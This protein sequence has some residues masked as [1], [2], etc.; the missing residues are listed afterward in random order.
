MT[1]PS[2]CF[3]RCHGLRLRPVPELQTCLVYRP[4]PPRLFR[5]N[6]SAWLVLELCDGLEWAALVEAYR[7]MA[8]NHSSATEVTAQV[9]E[10]LRMLMA[11]GLV[12]PASAA[13]TQGGEA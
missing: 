2:G 10:G 12:S 9:A 8:G 3:S 13:A 7:K 5:L 11:V 1:F 4:R 6:Y